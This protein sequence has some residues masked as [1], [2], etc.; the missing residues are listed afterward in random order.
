MRFAGEVVVLV[1]VTAG[2]DCPDATPA[3]A[4]V[5]PIAAALAKSRRVRVSMVCFVPQFGL[6]RGEVNE[7]LRQTVIMMVP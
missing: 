6:S 5:M 1:V 7:A 4:A 3:V 2:F